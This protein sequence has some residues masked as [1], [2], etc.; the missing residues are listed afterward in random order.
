MT[1]TLA[2]E[3]SSIACEF[4]VAVRSETL[5]RALTVAVLKAERNAPHERSIR[6]HACRVIFD[7]KAPNTRT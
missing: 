7:A 1:M 2:L 4:L 3:R 5:A 6:R